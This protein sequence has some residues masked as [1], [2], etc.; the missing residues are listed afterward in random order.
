MNSLKV[1]VIK[2]KKTEEQ[3]WNDYRFEVYIDSAESDGCGY[4]DTLM[5]AIEDLSLRITNFGE[6]MDRRKRCNENPD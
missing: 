2:Y 1:D 4:G 3:W 5:E 6:W